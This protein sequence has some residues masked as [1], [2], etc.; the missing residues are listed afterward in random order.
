MNL[1]RNYGANVLLV[2]SINEHMSA[3]AAM[4]GQY[5]DFFNYRL[6][7]GGLSVQRTHVVRTPERG[8]P[9]A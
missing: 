9:G 1:Q 4:S 3:G 5:S 6:K 8:A 2:K 7:R